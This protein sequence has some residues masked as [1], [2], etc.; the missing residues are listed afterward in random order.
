MSRT[1]YLGEEQEKKHPKNLFFFEVKSRQKHFFHI[2]SKLFET[3]LVLGVL[4]L[5]LTANHSI[6]TTCF[7]NAN[8]FW[9][10]I[11]Q[12]GHSVP[13]THDMNYSSSLMNLDNLG[14]P[15]LT[16]KEVIKDILQI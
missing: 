13:P 10:K 2:S 6:S 4:I 11:P 15:F 14:H 8:S 1:Q 7:L 9:T 3:K 5:I 16:L 12:T